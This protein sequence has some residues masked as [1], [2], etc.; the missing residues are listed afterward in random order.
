LAR[1]IV[2]LLALA[3]VLAVPA[4]RADGDPAS[5]FL[6]YQQAFVPP[7]AGIP[8]AYSDQL[9]A[10][11]REAKA[12]GFTIRVALIGTRYDMGSVTV[13]YD[14]PT[15]YA[16]FLGEELSLVYKGRLLVV[17]KNGLGVSRHGKLIAPEQKVVERIPPPRAG[18]AALAS[19][20]TAA[21]IRLAASHGVV[22]PMPPLTASG[23]RKLGSSWRDRITIAVAALLVLALGAVAVRLRGRF[24]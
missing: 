11:I 12:R 24:R 10:T 15:Q 22:V 20:A 1:R 21:V 9:L 14:K 3:A 8:K 23:P 6:L 19:T 5:D 18:G 7:D 16:R 2:V 13:L 17:M 4:A